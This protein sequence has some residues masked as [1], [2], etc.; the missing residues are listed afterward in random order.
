MCG[1][2]QFLRTCFL[3]YYSCISRDTVYGASASCYPVAF[4]RDFLWG[5]PLELVIFPLN[6]DADHDHQPESLSIMSVAEQRITK[7]SS[8]PSPS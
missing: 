8:S 6:Q 1:H 7:P 2:P 4:T 3:T 5:P